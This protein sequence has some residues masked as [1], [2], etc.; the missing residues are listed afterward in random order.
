MDVVAAEIF[1]EFQSIGKR[2]VGEILVAEG[3]DFAL[4]NKEGELVFPFCAEL[5]ELHARHFGADAGSEFLDLASF[6]EEVCES[7]V[8]VSAV[9]DVREW[10]P[11]RIFLGVVP[12]G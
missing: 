5:A 2:E 12:G 1:P 3:D 7:W 4:G 11:G 8:R 10:F 6:W 9:L